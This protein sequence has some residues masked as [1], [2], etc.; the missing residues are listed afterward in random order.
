MKM[1]APEGATSIT[2]PSIDEVV[3]AADGSAEIPDDKVSEAQCFGYEFWVPTPNEVKAAAKAAADKAAAD[4][5]AEA[6]AKAKQDKLA[7][8]AVLAQ[9][10]TK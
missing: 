7:A 9:K 6:D 2:F 8:D 10:S 3:V 5:A 4:A 1:K